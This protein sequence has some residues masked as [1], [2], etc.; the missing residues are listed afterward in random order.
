MTQIRLD[1]YKGTRMIIGNEKRELVNACIR[2]LLQNSFQE[3]ELPILNSHYPFDKQ[4]RDET[5]LFTLKDRDKT[6]LCLASHYL[7]LLQ[8][9]S[10]YFADEDDKKNMKLFYLQKTFRY[11]EPGDLRYREFTEFGVH[12]LNTT[13][14]YTDY[15]IGLARAMITA[16][17][18]PCNPEWYKEFSKHI[19]INREAQMSYNQ[20][21]E[22]HTKLPLKRGFE[23]KCDLLNSAQR[24]LS[25][26]TY[27]GGQGFSF[28][29]DRFMALHEL[30]NNT[31]ILELYKSTSEIPA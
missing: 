24:I 8:T 14:D 6:N 30:I 21:I 17:I 16:F 5:E 9:L 31:E 22:A 28:G 29:I 18:T 2:H 1:C 3:I 11:E 4:H 19:K 7:P 20:Y 13:V 10:T 15:L 25:G 23:I 12:M 27:E 26:G